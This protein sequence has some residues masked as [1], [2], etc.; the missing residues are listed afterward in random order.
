MFAPSPFNKVLRLAFGASLGLL[1][2]KLTNSDQWGVFF[3]IS[4]VLLLGLIPRL[5]PFVVLQYCTAN[6]LAG[7]M[8][9]LYSWLGALSA[10][11]SLLVFVYFLWLFRLMA[12]GTLFVFAAIAI[13][14]GSIFLHFAS[15]PSMD[16]GQ[17]LSNALV[18]VLMALLIAGTMIGLFPVPEQP[19]QLPP[20]K[21]A[22]EQQ[23]QSLVAASLATLSFVV[24]QLLDLQDSLS[25]QA[26][27]IL[28]LLPMSFTGIVQA[29]LKR[30][31]GV[32]LGSA[33]AIAAQVLLYDN[34]QHLPL[35]LLAFFFGLL[36][37]ARA[38]QLEGP[39]S[40][41]AFGGMTTMAIIFGQYVKPDQDL[42][43]SA[44]YRISSVSIAVVITLVLATLLYLPLERKSPA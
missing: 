21:A 3:T 42:I 29:G 10:V 20:A 37:F 28:I 13:I 40:G 9:L 27:S 22:L 38:Q 11:M 35:T 34:Y 31:S 12:K 19:I 6:L 33:Y 41:V 26:S 15:Y 14:N 39:G 4:P 36:I 44:L 2:A 24:F 7:A 8:V 30:A 18:A 32:L 43:Y 25:A 5:T 1:L 23:Q 17:M 16:P